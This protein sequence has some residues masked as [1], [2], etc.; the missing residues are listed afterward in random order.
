[1]LLAIRCEGWTC[2]RPAFIV[3]R[4]DKLLS[5]PL[6]GNVLLKHVR[7]VCSSSAPR[8]ACTKRAGTTRS[9]A[10]T[11]RVGSSSLIFPC[12]SRTGTAG[13]IVAGVVMVNCAGMGIDCIVAASGHQA[14]TKLL[15]V[16]SSAAF[17]SQRVPCFGNLL[18]LPLGAIIITIEI[19]VVLFTQL[20]KL[21]LDFLPRCIASH[22]KSL[23]VITPRQKKSKGPSLTLRSSERADGMR[24]SLSGRTKETI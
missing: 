13:G 15:I 11:I 19:R 20:V 24:A 4:R 18:K 8:G 16:M 21:R 3:A 22:T 2:R 5:P 1:M 17:M 6:S 23:V 10:S 9:S 14:R 7:R 12:V